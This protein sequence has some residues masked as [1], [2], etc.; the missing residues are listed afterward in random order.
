MK[1]IISEMDLLI[2]RLKDRNIF[3]FLDFDGTLSPIADK[4]QDAAISPV[5]QVLLRRISKDR[6]INVAIISGRSLCDIKQTV[7]IDGIIYAGNHGMEMEGLDFKYEYPLPGGYRDNLKQ[8]SDTLHQKFAE[9]EGIIYED[10]GYCLGIHYRG[11]AIDNLPRLNNLFKQV[12][13]VYLHNNLI[14]I[15]HGKM[16]FEIQP[17]VEWDKGRAVLW[18]LERQ[19]T[20]RPDVNI[21]PIYIGDDQTDEDAFEA[22][23]NTG[24]TIVVGK[25]EQSCA[26]YYLKEAV[27][28]TW[29]LSQIAGATKP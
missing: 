13:S 12:I 29:F 3:L 16:V 4:P 7:D 21:Y 6:K 5:T 9:F 2:H 11:V 27:D 25:A 17:P 18:L 19:I 28:V 24:L 15:R 23:K 20:L 10:K 22:L 14:K 8:L 26:Q 1:Y